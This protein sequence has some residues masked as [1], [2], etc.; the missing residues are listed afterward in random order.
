[1]VEQS[2]LRE[3]WDVCKHQLENGLRRH[4]DLNKARERSHC[5]SHRGTSRSPFVSTRMDWPGDRD[6]TGTAGD[7]D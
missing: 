6:S 7:V 3:R 1:M 5:L 4:G 2:R